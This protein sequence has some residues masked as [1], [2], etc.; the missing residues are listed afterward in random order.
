MVW[1]ICSIGSSAAAAGFLRL[2]LPSRPHGG[3]VDLGS[4]ALGPPGLL[5]NGAFLSTQTLV[6]V[7]GHGEEHLLHVIRV[8]STGLQEGDVQGRGQVLGGVITFRFHSSEHHEKF[9]LWKYFGLDLVSA[10]APSTILMTS[11]VCCDLGLLSS[12]SN[13]H[14]S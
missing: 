13:I 10:G 1:V 12:K 9:P 7:R 3:A 8:L 2:L 11:V 6:D 14:L 5:V 4:R